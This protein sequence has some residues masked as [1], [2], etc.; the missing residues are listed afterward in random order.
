MKTANISLKTLACLKC[1]KNYT[2][3]R[4]IAVV[5]YKAKTTLFLHL[6]LCFSL[7]SEYFVLRGA[8]LTCMIEA[9]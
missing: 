3:L 4:Q 1:F 5:F 8:V 2:G 9:S 6:L 7:F